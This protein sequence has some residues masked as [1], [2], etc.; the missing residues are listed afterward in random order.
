MKRKVT[1]QLSGRVQGVYFRI[2]TQNHAKQ[3]GVNGFARNLSDGRVEVVAEGDG[4]KI[5]KLIQWCRKGPPRARVE[6]V[7]IFEQEA[8]G[9]F[10]SFD[11]L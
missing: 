5:D 4:E 6:H 11:I 7:E 3:L 2:F 8:D 10:S 1:I 9:A